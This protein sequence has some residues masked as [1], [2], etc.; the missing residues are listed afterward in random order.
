MPRLLIRIAVICAASVLTVTARAQQPPSFG[1]EIDVRV[2]NIE[3]VVTDPEGLRV[4]DLKPA[5]FRLLVDGKEVPIEYFSEIQ[6]GRSVTAPAAEEGPGT[7]AGVQ[8]VAPEGVVGTYYLVFVDDYFSIASLR[9][10]VLKALKADLAR[11][12]PEDR[13]AVVAYDGGRLA[14]LPDW[15][16]ARSDLDRALDQAMARTARGF[17]RATEFRGLQSDRE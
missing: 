16:G 8:S 9:N 13:M 3:V 12:G 5:D 1:E 2:V 7:A 4:P 6:E 11:L 17:D 15:S 14:P 10:E